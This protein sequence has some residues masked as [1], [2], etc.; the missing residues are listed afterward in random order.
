[1]SNT[2]DF[3]ADPVPA[4][5]HPSGGGWVADTATVAA[6]A[7]VG[8]G[9]RVYGGAQVSGRAMIYGSARVFG[10][11]WVYGGAQVS[12]DAWVSGGAQ[13]CGTA[14]VS[15]TARISCAADI[16][17]GHKSG[18]Y[19]T[20]YRCSRGWRLQYGCEVHPLS[21]WR[22][23][24]VALAIRHTNSAAHAIHTRAVEALVRAHIASLS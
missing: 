19:W 24:H 16:L 11:A 1:M 6:S 23:L 17:T 20:A 5:R 9:A 21:E 8:P 18:Y 2:F 3:G 4:H 14:L 7:Y 10:D 22:R 13:I 15:G 12:G